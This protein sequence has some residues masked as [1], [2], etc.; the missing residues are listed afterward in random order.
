MTTAVREVNRKSTHHRPQVIRIGLCQQFRNLSI[1]ERYLAQ[2]DMLP[3]NEASEVDTSPRNDSATPPVVA[4]TGGEEIM[5]LGSEDL[6]FHV[7]NQ[8]CK[9]IWAHLYINI[10]LLLRV[11]V[12]LHDFC[13]GG[14]LHMNEKG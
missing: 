5:R 6:S 11:K 2:T 14:V 12:E 3:S 13:S 9:M 8:I 4:F 1:L 10:N 7:P